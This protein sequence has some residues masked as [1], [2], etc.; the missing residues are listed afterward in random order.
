MFIIV[1]LMFKLSDI[2]YI[3]C[4]AN[5]STNNYCY[6]TKSLCQNNQVSFFFIFLIFFSGVIDI[7]NP[8]S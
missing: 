6:Y 4:G 2:L 7:P 5:K 1:K 3:I 8:F